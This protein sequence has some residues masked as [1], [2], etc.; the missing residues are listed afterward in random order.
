MRASIPAAAPGWLVLALIA[1]LVVMVGWLAWPR[2]GD[3]LKA[4]TERYKPAGALPDGGLEQVDIARTT[5]TVRA[6][7]HK[8]SP[9]AALTTRP[10][11]VAGPGAPGGDRRIVMS[12]AYCL[13]GRTAN[14]ERPYVSSVAM[15]GV[16]FGSRWRVLDGPLAGRIFT[17]ND[18]IGHS[19]E[20]DIAFPGDCVGA[21]NYGRRSVVIERV[22]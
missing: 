13:T 14:G 12:T 2:H 22:L 3:P 21:R 11:L 15:N 17:V 7:R 19:S 8:N 10:E 9:G 4:G 16:P 18:R 6:S 1:A 20:F 5:T